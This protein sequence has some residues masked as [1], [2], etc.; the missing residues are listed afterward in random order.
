ML[1]AVIHW[2]L[3]STSANTGLAPAVTMHEAD[4]GRYAMLR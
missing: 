4:A 3:R 2:L 1:S